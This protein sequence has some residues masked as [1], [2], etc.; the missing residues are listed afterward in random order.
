V[1]L[2]I[3]IVGLGLS[4]FLLVRPQQ[5]AQTIRLEPSTPLTSEL[6]QPQPAPKLEIK[7]APVVK[8]RPT[9]P[10]TPREQPK[11]PVQ[12]AETSPS[13]SSQTTTSSS[14]QTTAS[15]VTQNTTLSSS[16]DFQDLDKPPAPTKILTPR[17]DGG[18]WRLQVGAFKSANNAD[19]LRVK[20]LENGLS[21]KVL[22]GE[23]GISRVLVGDYATREAAQ[24]DNNQVSSRVP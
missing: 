10:V 20:L 18:T 5:R 9:Q 8:P 2:V 14:N 7:P 12:R 17:A 3:A 6:S 15:S 4:V 11:L 21:A 16:R 13:S 22:R 1:L 19:A 23:D 24:A